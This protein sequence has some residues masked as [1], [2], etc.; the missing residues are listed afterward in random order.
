MRALG[1]VRGELGGAFE[2]GAR[3]GRAA[4]PGQV[5]TLGNKC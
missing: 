2:L 4:E 3:L 5:T 1:L